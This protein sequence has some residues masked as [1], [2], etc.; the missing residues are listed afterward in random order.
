MPNFQIGTV[1][2]DAR[3][4]AGTVMTKYKSSMYIGP[5]LTGLT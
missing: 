3:P 5:A 2:A 4:S 1:P